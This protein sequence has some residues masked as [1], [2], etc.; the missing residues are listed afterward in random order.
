MEKRYIP[1]QFKANN[2]KISQSARSN[3]RMKS[4]S[5]IMSLYL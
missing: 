5:F 1:Q 3:E 2:D 4:F